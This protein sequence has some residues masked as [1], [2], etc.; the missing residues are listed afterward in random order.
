MHQRFAEAGVEVNACR[1]RVICEASRPKLALHVDTFGHA[2]NA[3]FATVAGDDEL[4]D[5]IQSDH[6]AALYHKAWLHGRQTGNKNLKPCKAVY[7]HCPMT[8]DEAMKLIKSQ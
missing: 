5:Q 4:T 3:F 7:D 6:L 1:Q 8:T 2:L